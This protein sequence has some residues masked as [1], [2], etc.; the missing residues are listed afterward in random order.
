MAKVL[1]PLIFTKMDVS[2]IRVPWAKAA[3]VN[4]IRPMNIV[5]KITDLLAT[6]HVRDQG[7][8]NDLSSDA[9]GECGSY[10]R[11]EFEEP[12]RAD[13]R[14][15][16]RVC[17]SIVFSSWHASRS[18]IPVLRISTACWRVSLH[19]LMISPMYVQRKLDPVLPVSRRNQV[20]TR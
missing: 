5:E 3:V 2:F 6:S 16:S 7:H 11:E 19:V 1:I 14:A 12:T 13:R 8:G 10:R 15:W 18:W 9:N 20:P 4:R 17:T